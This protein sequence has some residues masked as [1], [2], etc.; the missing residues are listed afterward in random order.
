MSQTNEIIGAL[1]AAGIPL[2]TADLAEQLPHIERQNISSLCSQLRK[3]GLIAGEIEGQRLMYRPAAGAAAATAG[4]VDAAE[5]SVDA[6]DTRE[7]RDAD[8]S[9]APPTVEAVAKPSTQSFSPPGLVIA[10]ETADAEKPVAIGA[11]GS[12]SATLG[13]VEAAV[14]AFDKSR[15]VGAS[16]GHRER[17]ATPGTVGIDP[18]HGAD[19]FVYA[20]LR[21][22]RD[23]PT[24]DNRLAR[25]LA[26][27]VLA[28]WP[29]AIPYD[30]QRLVSSAATLP[31]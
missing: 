13:G 15:E 16:A 17:L 19:A 23:A 31:L 24:P 12:F 30:V 5:P 1:E 6:G 28:R 22:R 3:R 9:P 2:S 20:T 29:G 27:A 25:E 7:L 26:A 10:V 14:R 11:G 8:G 21:P 4:D 18:A